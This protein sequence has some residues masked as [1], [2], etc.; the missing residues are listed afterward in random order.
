ML[1]LMAQRVRR[2]VGLMQVATL[3]LT[4]GCPGSLC[5]DL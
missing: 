4:L 2:V 3:L 5:S 1:V